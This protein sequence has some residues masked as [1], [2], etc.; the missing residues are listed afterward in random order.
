MTRHTRRALLNDAYIIA[1][2]AMGAALL[3]YSGGLGELFRLTQDYAYLQIV[4]AGLFFTSVFTTPP[5]IAALAL[6]SQAHGVVATALLG[7]LGSVAGD[8][9]IFSFVRNH[10]STHV[11]TMVRERGGGKRL[12]LLA[13]SR[14]YRSLTFLLGGLIIASPLPDELGISLL[15]FS[16]LRMRWLVPL[17][18]SFN[19]VG[20]ALIGYASRAL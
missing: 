20:I 9:I 19:A 4:T 11:Q 2:S 8:L 12:R 1:A 7:A 18:F 16:K 14:I 15:G 17:S 5:A 3:V 6:L 13:H 10:L